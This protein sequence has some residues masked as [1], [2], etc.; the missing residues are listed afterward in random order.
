MCINNENDPQPSCF[1]KEG[2]GTQ[3]QKAKS[4]GTCLYERKLTRMLKESQDARSTRNY[5]SVNILKSANE[6]TDYKD[7]WCHIFAEFW[8]P[9]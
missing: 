2:S 1:K 4:E 3:T 7:R 6:W 5:Y 8:G 9:T